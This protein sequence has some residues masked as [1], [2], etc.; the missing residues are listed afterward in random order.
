[1]WKRR[2]DNKVRE[3]LA[4]LFWITIVLNTNSHTNP[5]PANLLLLDI[6][7]NNYSLHGFVI[8]IFFITLRILL[9]AAMYACALSEIVRDSM[10]QHQTKTQ[11]LQ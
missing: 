1:V 5:F 11:I 2:N 9:L 7:Q 6:A 8:I 3:N 10:I 4:F